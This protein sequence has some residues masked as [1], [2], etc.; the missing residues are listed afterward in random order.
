MELKKLRE[1]NG[2]TQEDVA[3]II[4]VQR[5]VISYYEHGKREIPVTNLKKLLNF[6][7]IELEDFKNGKYEKKIQVAYRKDD[8][9]EE[10]FNQVIWLNKFVMNLSDLKKINTEEV[11]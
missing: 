5:E 6:L 10:D 7:G 2:L 3:K 11:K 9:S 4:G 1:T 8:I